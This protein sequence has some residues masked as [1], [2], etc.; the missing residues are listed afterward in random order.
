M[1]LEDLLDVVGIGLEYDLGLYRPSRTT[2]PAEAAVAHKKTG[3]TYA[4]GLQFVRSTFYTTYPIDYIM[5]LNMRGNFCQYI[6]LNGN[7][8]SL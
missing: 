8:S 3:R 4:F 5:K 7:S 2:R 6:I 1:S